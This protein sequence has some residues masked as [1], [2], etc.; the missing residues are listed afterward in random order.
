[1]SNNPF[2]GRSHTNTG[3]MSAFKEGTTMSIDAPGLDE[4]IERLQKYAAIGDTDARR[5]RA[6]MSKSVKLVYS[7]AQRHV[8]VRTGRLRGTLFSKTKVWAEGNASGYVGSDAKS[9]V[10][11]NGK[12]AGLVPL[13]LDVGR[14]PNRRGRMEIKPLHWLTR[15]LSENIARINQIFKDVIDQITQDLAGK[16]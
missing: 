12:W 10:S 14:H 3:S 4:L 1:M 13:V 8:P 11:R 7:S 2:A 5:V 16:D 6:G 15:S 9:L